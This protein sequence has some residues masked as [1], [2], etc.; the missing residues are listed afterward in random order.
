MIHVLPSSPLSN[1]KALDFGAMMN[2]FDHHVSMASFAVAVV[3]HV[4]Y[5]NNVMSRK[6]KQ[7]QGRHYVLICCKMR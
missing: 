6:A 4:S 5:M 7:Q 3:L 2:K 1:Q